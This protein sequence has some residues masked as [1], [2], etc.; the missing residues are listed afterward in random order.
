M[1]IEKY[2]D[3]T[4]IK[5]EYQQA[6][7]AETAKALTLFC[8]QE[9]GYD[10]HDTAISMP[11]DFQAI[12][13]RLSELIKIKVSDEARAAFGENYPLRKKLEYRF[14]SL[15]IRQP[16]SMNE[17]VEEGSLLHHCVGGYAERNST[18][19]SSGQRTSRTFRIT[20]WS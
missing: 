4:K 13:E 17:I 12:H 9:L 18:Y 16:E 5:G 19:F 20:Q 8:E 6:V 15:F 14:G 1:N 2:F 11:H 3:R 10:M 7:A